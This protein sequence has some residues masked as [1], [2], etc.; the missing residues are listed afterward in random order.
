MGLSGEQLDSMKETLSQS[1]LVV[2]IALPALL[3]LFFNI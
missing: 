3:I 2:R 1:L